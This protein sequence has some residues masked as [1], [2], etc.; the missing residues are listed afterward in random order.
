MNSTISI[1]TKYRV[2]PID[3]LNKFQVLINKTNEKKNARLNNSSGKGTVLFA[4]CFCCFSSLDIV[5]EFSIDEIDN[6]PFTQDENNAREANYVKELT[7][8]M[9]NQMD[10]VMPVEGAAGVHF[11]HH[12][13]DNIRA[14]ANFQPP[15]VRHE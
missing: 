13:D 14:S 11:L 15:R 12:Y 2:L 10:M 7:P 6:T 9:Y 1:L 3:L 4:R 5:S 8:F